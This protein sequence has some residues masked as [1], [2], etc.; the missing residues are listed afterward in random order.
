LI[1][2]TCWEQ[3]YTFE[4]FIRISLSTLFNGL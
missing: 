1:I 2:D 4:L 3:P